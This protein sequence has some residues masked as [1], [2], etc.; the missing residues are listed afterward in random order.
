MNCKAGYGPGY[1]GVYMGIISIEKDTNFCSYTSDCGGSGV[2]SCAS[3]E[4][5]FIL[6]KLAEC[7]IN[8]S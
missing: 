2:F 1:C 3:F 6:C 4:R 8:I 7:W 5:N